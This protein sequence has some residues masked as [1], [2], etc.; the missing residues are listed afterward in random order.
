ML[1]SCFPFVCEKLESSSTLAGIHH[2]FMCMK[3]HI[4]CLV[5]AFVRLLEQ[6]CSELAA[7]ARCNMSDLHP[8]F[9]YC[10]RN[11]RELSMKM[12]QDIYWKLCLYLLT[13]THTDSV[14]DV[15]ILLDLLFLLYLP[16][17]HIRRYRSWSSFQ[18]SPCACVLNV[19]SHIKG[20]VYTPPCECWYAVS[21]SW[22]S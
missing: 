11:Y 6:I 18:T 12:L 22:L 17:Q 9:T 16:V 5:S 19:Q 3:Q 21:V 20:V 1:M 7:E 13:H 2:L 8:S 4:C 10:P 14:T 15:S